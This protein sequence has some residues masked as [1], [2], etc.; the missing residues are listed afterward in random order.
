MLKLCRFGMS[1]PRFYKP[2]KSA[3]DGKETTPRRKRNGEVSGNRLGS[4]PV[5]WKYHF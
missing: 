5:F 4:V 3:V 2:A 1:L